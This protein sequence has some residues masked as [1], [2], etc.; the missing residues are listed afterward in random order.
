MKN[1]TFYC[2]KIWARDDHGEAPTVMLI[3]ET[4]D[5]L[6]SKCI[7]YVEEHK[8]MDEDYLEDNGEELVYADII[9]DII[10]NKNASPELNSI[11]VT[12]LSSVIVHLQ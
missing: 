7:E 2:L 4:L 5:I 9:D 10:T 8:H 3:C 6:K 11:Y 1:L 12:D